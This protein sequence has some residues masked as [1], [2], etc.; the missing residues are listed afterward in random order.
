MSYLVVVFM[1][2]VFTFLASIYSWNSYVEYARMN[3]IRTYLLVFLSGV[4]ALEVL[5]TKYIFHSFILR[6]THGST[7]LFG[8]IFCQSL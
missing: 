2:S 3:A 1:A 7:G 8:R 5:E 4:A 6:P